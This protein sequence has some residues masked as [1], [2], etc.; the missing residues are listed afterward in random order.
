MHRFVG[1]LFLC[2]VTLVAAPPTD[3]P[4][5][6]AAQAASQKVATCGHIQNATDCHHLPDG[7]E[8]KPHPGYD[9]YLSFLK[10][11][12]IDPASADPQIKHTFTALTDFTALDTAVQPLGVGT[13]Q[14]SAAG[15]LADRG[16]GEIDAVIGYL[17]FAQ[18]GGNEACNCKLTTLDDIDF[19]IGIGFDQQLA[20]KIAKGTFVVTTSP[21][22]T[23]KAKQTSVVVEATPHSRA[24]F[25]HA[26]KLPTIDALR[27][28]RVKVI[29]QLLFD[30]D[31]N[32]PDDTCAVPDA[33]KTKCWRASAWELHPI[34]RLFVCKTGKTCDNS[35]SP[36]WQEQP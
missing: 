24:A 21:T 19:H 36:N 2:A 13:H 1:L 32:N 17:Y 6:L 9:P 26:W 7:C 16:Q 11:Q 33:V 23:D 30:N 5:K 8:P 14:A 25:H 4:H 12:L 3:R 31:H 10:N 28:R 18:H 15:P 35:S 29:G 22:K 20:A 27:G 34:T